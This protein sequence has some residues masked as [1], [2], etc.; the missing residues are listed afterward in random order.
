MKIGNP[1]GLVRASQSGCDDVAATVKATAQQHGSIASSCS[2]GIDSPP[3][4]ISGEPAK[5]PAE[6]SGSEMFN[7]RRV[8]QIKAAV[9]DGSFKVNAKKVA[10]KLVAGNLEALSRRKP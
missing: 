8:A 7:A 6:M 3:I 4:K 9:A 5:V 10:S 1:P 2:A